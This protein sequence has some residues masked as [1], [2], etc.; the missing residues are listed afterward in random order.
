MTGPILWWPKEWT[1]N[2]LKK[3]TLFRGGPWGRARDWNWHNVLGF[4]CAVPLLL[5]VVTGVI[6]S[7][8]WANN[9]L[10]RMTGNTPPPPP[11]T[12]G[13]AAAERGA[14][15]RKT[16]RPERAEAR[17]CRISR[18]WTSC[19]LAPASRFRT[20]RP[21]ACG[22]RTTPPAHLPF[23]SIAEMAAVPTCGRNS[24]WTPSAGKSCAGN[25][26]PA[27]TAAASSGPG[28]ASPIPAR[29]EGWL[30][31][32]SLQSLPRRFPAGVYRAL[33]WGTT[34]AGLEG[35]AGLARA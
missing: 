3:I 1:W 7:Y 23:R 26:S 22:C 11:Q 13:Q 5:I 8:P 20:G 25:P 6:M 17:S 12:A 27:T 29:L 34:A 15:S 30:G 10:Y 24:R 18:D 2:N 19:L 28:P 4:W 35:P 9:L 14:A 21:S 32:P 33:A 16:S 31:K